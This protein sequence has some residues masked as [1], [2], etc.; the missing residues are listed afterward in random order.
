[1]KKAFCL[2][3]AILI[4]FMMASCATLNEKPQ[5]TVSVSGSGAVAINADMVTFN[6]GVSETAQTTGEAQ[7]LANKKISQIL[8]ILRSFGIND[9]DMTTANLSF[10]SDY[11]WDNNGKQIKTGEQVSQTIFV[12]MHD[13]DK[14]ASLMDK[15]GTDVSGIS[16]NSVSFTTADKTQAKHQARELA[17]EDAYEKAQSYA[18]SCNMTVGKPVSISEGSAYFGTRMNADAKMAY[19]PAP[20]EEAVFGTEAPSGQLSVNVSCSIVFELY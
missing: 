16:F 7:Q 14:F 20:T 5:R 13:I 15:L 4:V 2:F 19:A 3:A 6:I 18:S 12:E 9:K 17:Y 10:Y 11:Y 8:A 1:M